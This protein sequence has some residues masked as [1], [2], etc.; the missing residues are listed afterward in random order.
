MRSWATLFLRYEAMKSV[1]LHTPLHY[2]KSLTFL[3][4]ILETP[5]PAK[6]SSRE[7]NYLS[8]MNLESLE[9]ISDCVY[10]SLVY[11]RLLIN[12]WLFC[13]CFTYVRTK[14]RCYRTFSQVF[15]SSV[16]DL[17][18]AGDLPKEVYSILF[19]VFNPS[20]YTLLGFGKVG[21]MPGSAKSVGIR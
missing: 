13:Q 10:I 16:V 6:W 21:H 14:N 15:K 20:C 7:D 17:V 11:S 8:M 5:E 2:N 9:E 3:T 12:G 19:T 1:R 4:Q 18:K